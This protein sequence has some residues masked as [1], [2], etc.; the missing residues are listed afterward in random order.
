M[1]R[2]AVTK[3]QVF[4]AADQFVDMG[5]IPTQN[6]IIRR[7]GG[8]FSTVGKH[9]EE[10][11]RARRA[12]N[13]NPAILPP[14]QLLASAKT[15]MEQIWS[16]ATD[17]ATATLHEHRKK[18]EAD[19]RAVEE[20]QIDMLNWVREMESAASLQKTRIDSLELSNRDAEATAATL[21]RTLAEVRTRAAVAEAKLGEAQKRTKELTQSIAEM[22]Q[23]NAD[24]VQLLA[25][26]PGTKSGA[27]RRTHSK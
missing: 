17:L 21:R 25:S 3:E 16:T 6:A 5:L 4:E 7:V 15:F 26:K 11:R 27:A 19:Q 23:R 12:A 8:S 24:L 2:Q 22:N 18:L 10:W 20:D 1:R 9:M 14:D 13:E